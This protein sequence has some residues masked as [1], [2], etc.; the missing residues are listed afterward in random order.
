MSLLERE[1]LRP[2][3]TEKSGL[4]ILYYVIILRNEAGRGLNP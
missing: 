3:P 4:R 2:S 1:G